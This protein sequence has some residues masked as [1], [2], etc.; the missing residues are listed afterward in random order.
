MTRR[1]CGTQCAAG[2]TRRG[3]DPDVVEPTVP[4]DL[5]VGDAVQRDPACQTQVGDAG[6]RPERAGQPQHRFLNHGLHRGGQIHVPL[7]QR[8][9]GRARRAAEQRLEPAVGHREAGTVVEIV[10]VKAER[11][12]RL[13]VDHVVEDGAHVLRLAVGREAHHLVFAGIDFETGV[14]GERRIEQPQGV[15]KIDLPR[16]LQVVAVT[17][18]YGGGGPLADPVH[19]QDHRVPKGR[20]VERARRVRLMVLGKQQFGVPIHVRGEASQFPAQQVLLKQLLL[21]P[22]RYRHGEGTE[23]PRRECHVGFEEPFELEERLVVEGNP[24]NVVECDAGFIETPSDGVG[25]IARVVF[26]AREA[27]LLRRGHDAPV[28]HQGRGAVVVERRE[29][30]DTHGL[31]DCIDHRRDR[32]ALTQHDQTAQDEHRNDD[33]QQPIFLPH[34]HEGPEFDEKRHVRPLKT[35]S[36]WIQVSVP[37]VCGESSSSRR[38]G[39][40]ADATGP[41]PRRA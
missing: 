14:E 29:A 23:A 39:R 35:G 3:L 32:G 38:S 6:L 9:N 19:G 24:V 7:R 15:R 25:G 18:P 8:L 4:Q 17:D 37:V 30:E 34:A 12:V 28:L 27:F 10:E 26:L 11:A 16:H 5:A 2:V 22:N 31:K 36:S 13:Q 21:D 33:R 1:Q 40:A 41:S 20:R